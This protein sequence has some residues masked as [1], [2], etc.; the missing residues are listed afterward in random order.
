MASINDNETAAINKFFGAFLAP[1]LDFMTKSLDVEI[2]IDFEFDA[3]APDLSD[4]KGTYAVSVLNATEGF[5][6]Y[7][8]CAV[9]E[10]LI[11]TVSDLIMGGAGAGV[12]KGSLTELEINASA[13]MIENF[14]EKIR[15]VFK[16]NYKKEL[17]F[18]SVPKFLEKKAKGYDEAF[19]KGSF[20]VA[21]CF[22]MKIGENEPFKS[23]VLG[24]SEEIITGLQGVHLLDVPVKKP[25]VEDP[26]AI[27]LA[28]PINTGKMSTYDIRKLADV[29]IDITAELG[30]AQVSIKQILS[31]VKG[32]ILELDTDEGADIVVFANGSEVA[33]AQV[34]VVDGHFGIKI[35][36][37]LDTQERYKQ[38]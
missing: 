14:F 4:Y 25:A 18:A 26:V 30:K 6:G 31:L 12:Y 32:S 19:D 15:E 28:P 36:K 9:P 37:I 34:V 10:A 33:K 3:N 22:S 38:I 23:Y 35:T 29:K 13:A 20:D 24:N 2:G 11:A 1:M 8:L 16:E 21:S 7:Y 17:H 27:N 5:K